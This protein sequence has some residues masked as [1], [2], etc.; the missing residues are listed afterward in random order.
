MRVWG[1][2]AVEWPACSPVHRHGR[3]AAEKVAELPGPCLRCT[4]APAPAGSSSTARAQHT[5]A[6]GAAAALPALQMRLWG[7]VDA[8]RAGAGRRSC[9][10]C[11]AEP[12]TACPRWGLRQSWPGSSPGWPADPPRC[13]S[14]GTP[15]GEGPDQPLHPGAPLLHRERRAAVVTL[16]QQSAGAPAAGLMRA[17]MTTGYPSEHRQQTPARRSAIS[18][19]GCSAKHAQSHRAG[20]PQPRWSRTCCRSARACGASAPG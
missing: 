13:C 11:R 2:Q 7:G 3:P 12:C 6:G 5:A 16:G 8:P 20:T 1:C 10:S 19:N 9:R 14:S 15:A 4:C 17:P 18:S